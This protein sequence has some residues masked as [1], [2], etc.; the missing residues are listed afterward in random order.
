MKKSRKQSSKSEV[1]SAGSERELYDGSVTFPFGVVGIRTYGPNL[2]GLDFL[3]PNTPETLPRSATGKQVWEA[4]FN[5]QE[6]PSTP[7]DVVLA[8]EGTDYQKKVWNAL[9]RI[10]LGQVWTYGQ[11]AESI[12]SG[13]RAA[14]NACRRNRIPILIPCHRIVAKTGLGGYCGHSSGPMLEVKRWLL[15]HEGVEQFP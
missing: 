11:L 2:V 5:Y 7:I 3:P 13:A 6:D 15:A 10:P 12:D 1:I 9:R 4:L 8:S 14:A